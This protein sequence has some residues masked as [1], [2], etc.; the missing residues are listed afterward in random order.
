MMGKQ[1][2]FIN[3]HPE[4]SRNEKL[5]LRH[6]LRFW[7]NI[8]CS[9]LHFFRIPE[10]FRKLWK[11]SSIIRVFDLLSFCTW[12]LARNAIYG[13]NLPKMT[14]LPRNFSKLSECFEMFRKN[15]F[16]YSFAKTAYKQ[17]FSQSIFTLKK[18]LKSFGELKELCGNI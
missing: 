14:L 3:R 2:F 4:R 13:P 8:H 7:H 15:I 17:R 10:T 18:N 16:T 11:V 12:F 9:R 6:T 5:K 1:V